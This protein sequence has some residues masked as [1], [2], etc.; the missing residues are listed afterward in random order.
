MCYTVPLVASAVSTFVW[1]RK[2]NDRKIGK[3]NLLFYGASIFGVIDHLW[4]GEL[5]LISGNTAKDLLLGV[6]ITAAIFAGWIL[7]IRKE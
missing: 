7:S 3:L 5:F 2:G 1:R 6:V 4:N